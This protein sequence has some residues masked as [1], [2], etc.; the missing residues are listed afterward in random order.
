MKTR[1]RS[2]RRPRRATPNPDVPAVRKSWLIIDRLASHPDSTISEIA[3]SLEMSKSTTHA[4]VATLCQHGVV[5][6]DEPGPSYRLG[7]V[8]ISLGRDARQQAPHRVMVRELLRNFTRVWGCCVSVS[9]F[10]EDS[11]QFV[12]VDRSVPSVSGIPITA[13]GLRLPL[14]APAIG[15]AYL[16]ACSDDRVQLLLTR[17]HA[18]TGAHVELDSVLSRIATVRAN[19]YAVSLGDYLPGHNAVGAAVLGHN[20]RPI[21]VLAMTGYPSHLSADR[22]P[23]AGRELAALAADIRQSGAERL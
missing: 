15:G 5:V 18:Q 21:L 3:S 14:L 6:R 10:I 9:E 17:W 8:L 19:G 23:Q 13:H 7:P 16:A 12:V 11:L 2:G 1:R 4:I 20:A 22:V